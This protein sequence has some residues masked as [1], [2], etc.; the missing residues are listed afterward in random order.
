[1]HS[2]FCLAFS[3]AILLACCSC[4]KQQDA[5]PERHSADSLSGVAFDA[6]PAESRLP[7]DVVTTEPSESLTV[8]SRTLGP[9]TVGRHRPR[10]VYVRI[11]E[12]HLADVDTFEWP[13]SDTAFVIVDS[14]GSELV[15]RFAGT[16]IGWTETRYGCAS[17]P[18]PTAG[19]VLACFTS[20][21]P[22]DPGD[23][24]DTEYF[25]LDSSGILVPITNVIPERNPSIVF[26]DPTSETVARVVG[27]DFPGGVPAFV[28]KRWTG[29]FEVEEFYR[30][31]PDGFSAN[32]HP[33]VFGFE[34]YRVSIDT[35][36]ARRDRE[37]S[38]DPVTD[39]SLCERPDQDATC[40][41]RVEVRSGSTIDF[42]DAV[43]RGGWWLHVIIDGVDGYVPG[44]DH[45][46]L[47]LPDA[48]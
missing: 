48:G 24:E 26:L 37:G 12:T 4:S 28:D 45:H 46:A 2:G 32:Q 20:I 25:G 14:L 1:M 11:T 40:P 38:D 36:L 33:G 10:T 41:R 7:R 8:T 43:Y 15:S 34:R 42:L 21:S 30:I 17:L 47:G 19:R 35:L 16:T 3:G 6:E 13:D 31:Y 22:S 23:G 9:F 18:V 27:Q 29:N 39:V 44:A 5:L